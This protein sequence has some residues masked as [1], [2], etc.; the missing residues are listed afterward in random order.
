MRLVFLMC[1]AAG[2][3]F[4]W[5]TGH[6]MPSIVA[7]HFDAGGAA[8][9]LMPR[10]VYLAVMIGV[11]VIVPS[12]IALGTGL[13]RGLPVDAISLPH[14]DIWLAPERRE[15][16][17]RTLS[18]SMQCFACLLIVFLC[19]V[20]HEVVEANL[21][22]PPVLASRGFFIAVVVFLAVTIVGTVALIRRF[23]IVR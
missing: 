22:T 8:N 5:I 1:V 3:I 13:L 11:V 15:A 23:A 4:V 12:A 16:T 10:H 19:F 14:R 18:S 6:A 9:G 21:R 2:G 17:L 7:S 20:H